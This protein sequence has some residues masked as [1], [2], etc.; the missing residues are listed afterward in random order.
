MVSLCA[1]G[2]SGRVG[3]PLDAGGLALL[4]PVPL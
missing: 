4:A 1:A 2:P 3:L